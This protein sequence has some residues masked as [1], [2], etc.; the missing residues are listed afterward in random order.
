MG[1]M[2][3]RRRY[4][5]V[6][7]R[8]DLDRDTLLRDYVARG[9]PVVI[10]TSGET[11]AWSFEA[12]ANE[13][14]DRAV[15]AEETL[16]V[17]VGERGQRRLA[18]AE[19][20]GRVRAN[21]RSLRWKGLDLLG[22][23]RGMTEHLAAAPPASEALLPTSTTR[24][25]RALWLAPAGTM[26]SFHH[27]GNSDNLNWQV[28]GKKLFLLAPPSVF[29]HVYAYGSAQSPL[30]PFSP[31]LAR[32]PRFAA[33]PA[34]EALLEPGDVLLIPK[35][36]WHCVYTVEPSVNLNTWFACPET[37]SA[38]RALE[39]VPFF[40]RTCSTIAAEMKKREWIGLA[41]MLRKVW[42]VAY[43][44][45]NARPLP[46]PRGLLLDP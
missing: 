3:M 28:S 11:D 31:D 25:S 21:D 43:A 2:Q 8:T 42:S 23:V 33:A 4:P 18:L 35:Y 37:V 12:L 41:A 13:F 36:W 38:W 6:E 45:L 5:F 40:H 26:S 24:T 14:G 46:D 22:A 17:F 7:R 30:N 15:A 16:P 44:Q 9:E 34:C 27:D 10:R 20:I 32:F 39:G 29:A 19:V 1:A